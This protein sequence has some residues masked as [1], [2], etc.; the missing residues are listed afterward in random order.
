MVLCTKSLEVEI[1]WHLLMVPS[2]RTPTRRA[3]SLTSGR[4]SIVQ[5]GCSCS[6]GDAHVPALSLQRRQARHSV[7]I[8]PVRVSRFPAG[9]W[10]GCPRSN[11]LAYT[12]PTLWEAASTLP[13]LTIAQ[14]ASPGLNWSRSGLRTRR[15]LSFSHKEGACGL[16]KTSRL[17][18]VA[19]QRWRLM[20]VGSSHE[21][22]VTQRTPRRHLH[23]Q[24]IAIR[25]DPSRAFEDISTWGGS[26]VFDEKNN[27]HSTKVQA[28]YAE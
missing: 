2:P 9:V 11:H 17:A 24:L 20:M 13:W 19:G 18:F 26:I 3:I 1:S 25:R 27:L 14:K 16:G 28:C 12:S 21:T 10:E 6:A 5:V 22:I 23:E 15:M 8:A 4:T 7:P